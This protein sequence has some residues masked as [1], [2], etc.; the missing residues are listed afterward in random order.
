[1][2]FQGAL[3]TGLS[4][5]T[6]KATGTA[7]DSLGARYSWAWL[8]Q[9]DLGAKVTESVHLGIYTSVGLGFE[10]S[11]RSIEEYC[12]DDDD[13][14]ENDISCAA[15]SLRFGAHLQYHFAPDR[16]IDPW[17]GYGLGWEYSALQLTDQRRNFRESNNSWGVTY[18]K[19]DGGLDF[20]WPVGLGFYGEAAVG[21]FTRSSTRV[22]QQLTYSGAVPNP[23][24]HAWL[25][26][27]LRG[28]LFP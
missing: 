16:T 23:A 10:G 15:A 26:I 20:R 24:F 7:G 9:L 18:A 11:D 21:R 12:D 22:N 5:P 4:I 25:T 19:L 1:L 13:D 8:W 6:G 27:G 14:F 28:V 2:G 3:R 17:L